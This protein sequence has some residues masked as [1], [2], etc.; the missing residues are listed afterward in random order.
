MKFILATIFFIGTIGAHAQYTEWLGSDRPGASMSPYTVGK[1]TLQFQGGYSYTKTEYHEEFFGW[2]PWNSNSYDVTE[3]SHMERLKVRLGIAEQV[4][5]NAAMNYQS[6]I[7]NFSSDKAKTQSDYIERVEIGFRGC[8]LK[9]KG[10]RPAIGVELRMLFPT[11][12]N[13]KSDLIF[14]S[15]LSIQEAL[16]D[17]FALTGNIIY[18]QDYNVGFTFNAA[19]QILEKLGLFAEVAPN[20]DF[21]PDLEN[22][23]RA[24]YLNV[25]ASWYFSRNLQVDVAGSW[26]YNNENYFSSSVRDLNRFFNLQIGFSGRLDWRH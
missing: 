26:V 14:S 25:G 1:S 6:D 2:E 15:T 12:E 13:T 11:P 8:I 19:Y 20:Y 17:K 23:A 4:E 5:V 21:N 9:A 10:F 24:G 3:T 16:S 18:T 22:N 7:E